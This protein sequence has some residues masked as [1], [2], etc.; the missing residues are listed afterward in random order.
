MASTAIQT[1]SSTRLGQDPRAV[2]WAGSR[3]WA[4]VQG[5]ASGGDTNVNL[6]YSDDSGSSFTKLTDVM[7][8]SSVI[9][10]LLTYQDSG[11]SWHL[12]VV[13]AHRPTGSETE[14]LTLYQLH[15]NVATGTPGSLTAATTIDAGGSNAGWQFAV[16]LHSPSVSNRRLWVVAGKRLS[17][18]TW[19]VEYTYAGEGTTADTA[20]NWATLVEVQSGSSG[21]L[22]NHHA[23]AAYWTVSGNPKL[24]IVW[25]DDAG[26]SPQKLYA[27]TFDPSASTPALGSDTDVT[28]LANNSG[29]FTASE[30]NDG[31][32]ISVAAKADYLVVGRRNAGGSTDLARTTDGTSWSQPSGWS[33]LT[34]GRMSLTTDGTNFYLVY[35][36]TLTAI[37]SAVDALKYRQITAATDA[38][39]AEVSFSDTS[40]AAV[41][42]PP[43]TGTSLLAVLYRAST[44]SPYSVRFDSTAITGGGGSDTTAPGACT[45][46]TATAGSNG[47]TATI[48]FT[49][50][51]DT[52]V[53]QYKIKT[54]TS[55]YPAVHTDGTESVAAT[56]ADAST[57][58]SESLTGLTSS[59]RIYGAVFVKDDAGNWNT[60]TRFTFVPC[61]LP[62]F[63]AWRTSA[64]ASTTGTPPNAGASPIAE[65]QLANAN[66]E[67]GKV[68]TFR[69]ILG[70][71]NTTPPSGGTSGSYVEYLSSIN[72]GIFEYDDT[73]SGGWTAVPTS[74]LLTT[75]FTKK[76]RVKTAESGVV[77]YGALRVEQ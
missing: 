37:S 48:A 45:G 44:S 30:W 55:A 64:G 40:G 39:G 31:G 25:M 16:L 14:A 38:M 17:L 11:G 56:T 71:E 21:T 28:S 50:P 22:N 60:G 8:N 19:G 52:D 5:G 7:A 68:A 6:Y 66:F 26:S 41:S 2:G 24:T 62:S 74:G 33:G 9:P 49:T 65:F 15:T 35:V 54:S 1:S 32:M 12:A 51:S 76:L 77:L 36:A 34:T 75:K 46:V 27:N 4:V 29:S 73:G 53:A 72:T 58:Y 42:T 47:T 13:C 67:S 20:G 69:F 18:T 63:T 10:Q 43:N 3:L 23:V 61:T 57:T 70:T 59:T